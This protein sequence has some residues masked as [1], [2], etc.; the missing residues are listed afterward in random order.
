MNVI[1]FGAK[2]P[3]STVVGVAA[4]EDGNLVTEKKWKNEVIQIYS[5]DATPGTSAINCTEVDLS[6]V[7]AVSLRVRTTLDVDI[8]I[9]LRVDFLTNTYQMRDAQ[10]DILNVTVEHGTITNGTAAAQNVMITPDDFPAL[11]WLAKLR[12]YFQTTGTATTGTVA[13]YAVIKR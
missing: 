11:Q 10:G 1:P 9:G 4:N 3:T 8:N 12:V 13:I 6:N 2:S 5:S 7:G